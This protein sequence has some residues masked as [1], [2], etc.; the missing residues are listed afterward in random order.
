M[1]QY[2]PHEQIIFA[3]FHIIR[4]LTDALDEVRRQ[5]YKRVNDKERI[6]IKG[7]RYTLLSHKANLDEKGRRST[8]FVTWLNLLS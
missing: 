1:A 6:C 5:E 2:V 7:Q 8:S 4:H 3:K